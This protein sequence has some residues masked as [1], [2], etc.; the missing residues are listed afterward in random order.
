VDVSF[1]NIAILA[2]KKMSLP[3]RR[4]ERKGKTTGLRRNTG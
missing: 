2:V 1:A 3:Q 4:K